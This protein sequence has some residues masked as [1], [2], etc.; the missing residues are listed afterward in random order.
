M[1]FYRNQEFGEKMRFRLG[2]MNSIPEHFIVW[3]LEN[4]ASTRVGITSHAGYILTYNGTLERDS[5]LIVDY[6]QINNDIQLR[7]EKERLLKRC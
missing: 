6:K 2:S 3:K 7:N 5:E 1:D 4:K